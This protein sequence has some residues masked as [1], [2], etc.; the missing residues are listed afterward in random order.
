MLGQPP[1][2]GCR[3]GRPSGLLK[4]SGHPP[5]CEGEGWTLGRKTLQRLGGRLERRFV[6]VLLEGDAPLQEEGLGGKLGIIAGA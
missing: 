6:V 1:I 3:I 2:V 5:A 4:G